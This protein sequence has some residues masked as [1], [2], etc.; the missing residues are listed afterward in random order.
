MPG[1]RR[2]RDRTQ[3]L[4]E[5]IPIR[6]HA[7][8]EFGHAL[9]LQTVIGFARL[10]HDLGIVSATRGSTQNP[11]RRSQIVSEAARPRELTKRANRRRRRL[12]PASGRGSDALSGVSGFVAPEPIS[13]VPRTERRIPT[14]PGA[15][16]AHAQVWRLPG[17]SAP[18]TLPRT[19]GCIAPIGWHTQGNRL[20]LRHHTIFL[21][22]RP[23][24]R[25]H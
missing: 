14:Q 20:A 13:C 3:A 2:L 6:S 1:D 10:P 17:P 22:S 5:R 11:G 18:E 23:H 9:P 19:H 12:F 24:H 16:H 8:A 21:S 7:T 25:Q 15:R 4:I